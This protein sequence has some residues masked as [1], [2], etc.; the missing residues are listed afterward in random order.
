LT[1]GDITPQL[2]AFASSWIDICSPDPVVASIS[3]QVLYLEVAYAA[4]CGIEYVF[5]PAPKLYHEDLRTHGTAQYARSIQEALAIGSHLQI[6]ILLPVSDLPEDDTT[7][8]IGS[9]SPFTHEDYLEDAEESRPAKADCFGTWD[10]WNL[11]RTICKYNSRLF[12]GKK[13]CTV[14]F[15]RYFMVQPWNAPNPL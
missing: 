5:I 13:L 11:I 14:Y 6:F 8:E 9:L 2:L 7:E 12:V 3:K 15:S 1:P 10:A 4:F